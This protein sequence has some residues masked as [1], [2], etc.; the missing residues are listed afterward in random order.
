MHLET[1]HTTLL[2]HHQS[3]QELETKHQNLLQRLRDDQMKKQHQTELANQEEYTSRAQ[4]EL[5]HKHAVEAKQ[6][7]KNLKVSSSNIKKLS[8]TF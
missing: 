2:R 6:M 8:I 1:A 7:P 4:R 5:K 3:T